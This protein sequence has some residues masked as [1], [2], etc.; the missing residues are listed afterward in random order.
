MAS[1]NRA[2]TGRRLRSGRLTGRRRF[3]SSTATSV[4]SSS[5]RPSQALKYWLKYSP[6][7]AVLDSNIT[8]M[9]LCENSWR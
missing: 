4:Y 1:S 8:K 7:S 9:T 5:A 3:H 6:A 2:T